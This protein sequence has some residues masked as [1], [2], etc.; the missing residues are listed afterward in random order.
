MSALCIAIYGMFVAIVVPPA[1]KSKPL[2]FVVGIA[3]GLACLFTYVP[4]LKSVSSGL[5]VSIC[6]V[7]AAIIGAVLFPVGDESEGE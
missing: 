6:A 2:L 5:S 4:G 7:L 1:K 3:V